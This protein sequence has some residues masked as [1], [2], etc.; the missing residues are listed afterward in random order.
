MVKF[1]SI[2]RI[3]DGS[4]TTAKLANDAVTNVKLADEAA[5]A[6]KQAV[7]AS[8]TLTIQTTSTA[9]ETDN[10]DVVFA[11]GDLAAGD[12][13]EV[14]LNCLAGTAAGDV[15]LSIGLLTQG[16]TADGTIV[17]LTGGNDIPKGNYAHS[18]GAIN[19]NP[20][21]DTS[22]LMGKMSRQYS[23]GP[24]VNTS[25]TQDTTD[26]NVFATGFTLRITG[27]H[28]LAAD[29][30]SKINYIVKINKALAV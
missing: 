24:Q 29:N 11:A 12:W 28:A 18:V 2:S 13:I 20:G 8:G 27:K 19:Q 22:I 17:E 7:H 6:E 9:Y 30:D 23:G 25:G 3:V 1:S 16:S 4:V 26:D 10:V 21:T 5:S 15:D 14:F